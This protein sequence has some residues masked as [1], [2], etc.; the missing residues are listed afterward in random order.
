MSNSNRLPFT[1][2]G[3]YL[4][5]GKTTLINQMLSDPNAPRIGLLVNDFGAI[6]IDASLIEAEDDDVISLNNG[7]I[8]C[9]LTDS[10]GDAIDML[11][12][13]TEDLDHIILEASGVSDPTR[14]KAYAYGNPH[15]QP[16]P[17]V[18]LI[19]CANIRKQANDKF[20]KQLVRQQIQYADLLLLNKQDLLGPDEMADVIEWIKGLSSAPH[21]IRSD[22]PITLEAILNAAWHFTNATFEAPEVNHAHVSWHYPTPHRLSRKMIEDILLT[23]PSTLVRG[24]GWFTDEKNTRCLLQFSQGLLTITEEP[25]RA[26]NDGRSSP[27]DLIFLSPDP[28]FD[29]SALKSRLDSCK[30]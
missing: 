1:I 26:A 8:C 28:D 12:S 10:I 7:C 20:V 29:F 18:T 30:A 9:K 11:A 5:A 25:E 19:D 16:G 3:G 17:V 4:G 24:K 14:L 21:L 22:I 27:S 2:I 15:L 13:R 23:A 6:N